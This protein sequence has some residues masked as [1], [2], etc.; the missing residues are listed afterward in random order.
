MASKTDSPV[1]RECRPLDGQGRFP[2]GSRRKVERV[3][4]A[5]AQRDLD[6]LVGL[7]AQSEDPGPRR[8]RLQSFRSLRDRGKELSA[9]AT[10]R[11]ETGI[12]VYFAD[13]HSPWQRAG[14]RIDPANTILGL[15]VH[16]WTSL[17]TLVV[18]VIFF[19]RDCAPLRA[20]RN[21]RGGPPGAILALTKGSSSPTG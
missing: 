17:V 19:A 5:D 2:D 8:E 9:H 18:V 6:E 10:F 4:K 11:V 16:V 15:R 12:P 1:E 14:L 3:E 13:P 21:G 20:A 7:R